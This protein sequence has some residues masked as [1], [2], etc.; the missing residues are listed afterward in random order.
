MIPAF[1]DPGNSGAPLLFRGKP[2]GFWLSLLFPFCRF[3]GPCGSQAGSGP[4]AVFSAARL[5]FPGETA[6]RELRRRLLERPLPGN[7]CAAPVG[8]P[9]FVV[10][11]SFLGRSGIRL[12]PGVF[13][14][15]LALPPPAEL[16]LREPLPFLDPRRQRRKVETA[17]AELQ[18]ELLARA[19]VAIDDGNQFFAEGLPAVGRGSRLGPGT[20][21]RGESRIGRNVILAANCYIENS[22]IGDGCVLLP[23]SV[24][25][26]SRIEKNVQLGPYCHVRLGS[27]VRRGAK[28]GNFVEMKKSTF[29]PGSKAMHLTYLGDAAIG[30]RVNV[31]AGTITCNYDG[32]RKNPTRI[33]DD[34]FIGSGTEL[35]APVSVASDSYIAAGSTITENVPRHALAVA[36]QR[37]RNIKG[38]VL[39]KRSKKN[40]A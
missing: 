11:R 20:V 34:V 39:R 13:A 31:G 7:G 24:V 9:F 12:Q 35:V 23:G 27:L 40:Q 10:S 28:I 16:R 22:V 38:W 18:A 17:V 6:R 14:R 8:R 2:A 33:G 26:D 5:P 37:Q 3:A 1:L 32:V 30:A 21:I 4:V 25:L 15:L 36:R 19:G 29:G